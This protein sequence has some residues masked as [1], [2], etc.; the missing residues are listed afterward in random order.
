[1]TYKH[2]L[3]HGCDVADRMG[4]GCKT[5][6]WHIAEH[7]RRLWLIRHGALATDANNLRRLILHK[8]KEEH[9]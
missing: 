5:C 9:T 7:E 8:S 1:M 2:C 3:L 4:H 6:G